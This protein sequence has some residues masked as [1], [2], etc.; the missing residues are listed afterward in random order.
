MF[1]A[2]FISGLLDFPR[3][4]TSGILHTQL[5]NRN[6]DPLSSCVHSCYVVCRLRM[7]AAK[8]PFEPPSNH[9]TPW[10]NL[11]IMF[12]E[13]GLQCYCAANKSTW[14]HLFQF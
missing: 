3:H 12:I 10:F 5:I 13:S 6:L 9:I 4:L 11:E 1:R 14:K 7:R 8:N 2:S